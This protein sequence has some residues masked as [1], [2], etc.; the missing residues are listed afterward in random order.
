MSSAQWA[1]I[2]EDPGA[3]YALVERIAQ[4][5]TVDTIDYLWL[6]P[7]RKVAAGES[8]VVV[9]GL[10]DEDPDRRRV[11]TAHFTVSR[12]R[13]GAATVNARFDEH[14]SAP[15]AAVPRIVQ[16][17]LRRL[18]EDIEASPREEQIGG[19]HELWDALTVERGGRPRVDTDAD[20]DDEDASNGPVAAE[21]TAEVDSDPA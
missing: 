2:G 15:V 12:N 21:S 7:S 8:I 20:A 13:K 5:A 6:F 17:V 18:G 19:D 14:G 1:N 9:I 4:H 3:L 10:F 16:G 11:S